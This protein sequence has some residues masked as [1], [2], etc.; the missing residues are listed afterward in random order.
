MDNMMTLLHLH[1]GVHTSLV[2][3]S[4]FVMAHPIVVIAPSL[5]PN[6]VLSLGKPSQM[7][8]LGIIFKTPPQH[9]YIFR[10]DRKVPGK[11]NKRLTWLAVT[12]RYQLH[13]ISILY[14]DSG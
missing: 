5:S 14:F 10:R 3:V 7:S 1:C 12:D 9:Q 8:T 6:A 2:F 13:R 4:S 11:Q